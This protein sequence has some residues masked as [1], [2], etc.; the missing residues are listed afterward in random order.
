MGGILIMSHLIQSGNKGLAGPPS[1]LLPIGLLAG[2]LCAVALVPNTDFYLPG[3]L[4]ASGIALSVGLMFGV[5][6]A[7]CRNLDSILRIDHILMVGLVYWLVFDAVQGAYSL[8]GVSQDAIYT[9][10]NSTALFA[11]SVWV[12]SAITA[13]GIRL[14]NFAPQPLDTRFLFF[15][16]LSCA[17]L[18][19]LRVFIACRLNP[20]CISSSL[21]VPRFASVWFNADIG[22]F[23]TIL[24]RLQNFGYL[25]LPLAVALHHLKKRIDWQVLL[26][27]LLGMLFLLVVV[28][29]G[30]R[31]QAGMVVAAAVM[32]WAL[33]NRPL[34]PRNLL[35]L[36]LAGAAT[37][38][39][40]QLM[41]SWR[42]IGILQETTDV[43]VAQDFEP[44]K[45]FIKIDENLLYFARIADLVPAQYEHTGMGGIIYILTS[46]IPRALLPKKTISR[47]FP[48][49]YILKLRKGARWSW[50]CSA[51]C[52]FYLI[53]G[54]IALI[55]GG[56]LYGVLAGLGNRLLLAP[57]TIRKVLYYGIVSLT[58]FI[59]LRAVH[60]I[61]ITGFAVLALWALLFMQRFLRVPED[62]PQ[63]ALK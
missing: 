13:Q 53:G 4:T 40:V 38:A 60:E 47:D 14:P 35:V 33:L 1:L 50:T 16:G 7:A 49:V 44:S 30:G 15:A 32:V 17:L 20:V 59:G 8:Y 5:A 34:Q 6:V 9:V 10:F 22:H 61:M 63:E 12:G 39:L 25:I 28:Q 11:A 24:L 56:L 43:V 19:L 31:R 26:L 45:G 46:P 41:T 2:W 57:F 55:I 58:V 42:D 21:F 54:N 3:G 27:V 52:D 62:T 37:L 29:G 48:L 36:A 18:G 23:D 51:V